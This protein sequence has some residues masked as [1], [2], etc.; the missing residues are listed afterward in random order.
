MVGNELGQAGGQAGESLH[1]MERS[2]NTHASPEALHLG[3]LAFNARRLRP[4]VPSDD[5]QAG[6]LD[7]VAFLLQEGHFL[8]AE[9]RAVVR[10]AS[11]APTDADAFV[12]WFERLKDVGPGQGDP[13][14]P[15]LAEHASRDEMRWFV[16][17]ELAGEAGFDDLVALTQVKLP[18]RAKL[19]LARNY[20]DEM[21]HGRPQGMHGPMLDA[22]AQALEVEPRP[23]DTVWEALALANL[24]TG[25]ASNRRYAWHAVGALG[26][27]E[28]TAPGRCEQVDAG[29]AR[30][31]FSGP[32]RR[33][34]ML[35]AKLDISHSRTWNAEVLHPMVAEHPE[36]ARPI[37]EGALMRLAAGA[38]CFARYRR[39]LWA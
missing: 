13:L 36:L 24:L 2:L 31:G 11:H 10:W 32:E 17:Q 16:A 4:G 7:D 25:L 23:E 14:F 39:E 19:E 28:L 37:A 34:Y 12:A 8:E 5:W 9:R 30:L 18:A 3:L 20:W 33:Y 29:L 1:R 35:H 38:R 6:V 15:W 21:G 22:L 26:A 27:V